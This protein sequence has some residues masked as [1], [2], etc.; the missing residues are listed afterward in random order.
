MGIES[1]SIFYF[2]DSD[3]DMSLAKNIGCIPVGVSWGFK[4]K[5]AILASG[6]EVILDTPLEFFDFY[7]SYVN[8][9]N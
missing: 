8:A 6:A 2:G 9:K 7:S 1:K 3:V 4:S 5:E